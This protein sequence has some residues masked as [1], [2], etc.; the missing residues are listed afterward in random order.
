M[1]LVQAEPAL[2]AVLPLTQIVSAV[3]WSAA[4]TELC[5]YNFPSKE[6]QRRAFDA[7]GAERVLRE[8]GQKERG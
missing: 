2:R 8:T 4:E 6:R 7:N 1:F 3:K 5:Y